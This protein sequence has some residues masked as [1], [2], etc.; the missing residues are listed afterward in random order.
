MALHE[1]AESAIGQARQL[2]AAT[3]DAFLSSLHTELA[4]VHTMCILARQEQG[5]DRA[6]HVKQAETAFSVVLELAGRI[7][8]TAEARAE[9]DQ[10]RQAI[11]AL[12]GRDLAKLKP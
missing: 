4:V 11:H 10:A 3:E 1:E 9:I 6:H 2:R 12:G 8:L 7:T 5:A